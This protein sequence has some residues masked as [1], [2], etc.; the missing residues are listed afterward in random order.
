MP[1]QM[2]NGQTFLAPA[3]LVPGHFFW[4]MVGGAVVLVMLGWQLWRRRLQPL[5]FAATALLAL[6]LALL[7][8][9]TLFP[10]RLF[11]WGAPVYARG[12]GHQVGG[13]NLALGVLW[14][15]TADQ[16]GGNL[17]MLAPLAFFLALL[18]PRLAGLWANLAACFAAS[19]AIE[20][21]QLA[22]NLT[23]LGNRAFDVNDLLLNTLGSVAGYAAY[24]LLALWWP[25]LVTEVRRKV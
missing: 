11:P 13:V 18:W 2:D 4:L 19:L 1:I 9:V 7:A 8:R 5:R 24:R 14:D 15:Y 10:I 16:I 23:Y 22:M 6:Y 3:A 21:L 25:R 20:L 12:L 17:I